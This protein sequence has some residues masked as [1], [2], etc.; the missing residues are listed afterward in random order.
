MTVAVKAAKQR[1]TVGEDRV[2][3]LTFFADDVVRISE[4]PQGL[5]KCIKNAL[6]SA[7]NRK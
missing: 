2:S 6:E 1:V 7:T 5:Q 3:G 4:T